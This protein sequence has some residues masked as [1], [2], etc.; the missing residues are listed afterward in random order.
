MIT[1]FE[2]LYKTLATQRLQLFVAAGYLDKSELSRDEL[3]RLQP[4]IDKNGQE[5]FCPDNLLKALSQYSRMAASDKL[6]N[7]LHAL[8][9]FP[10]ALNNRPHSPPPASRVH[11]PA[12]AKTA[13]EASLGGKLLLLNLFNLGKRAVY[14]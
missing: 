9:N 10:T 12:V 4:G 3:A 1:A 14:R 6:N 13:N 7:Y 11:R 8:A 5:T 2:N